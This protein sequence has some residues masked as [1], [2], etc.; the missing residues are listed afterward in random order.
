MNEAKLKRLLQQY[1]NNTISRADCVELLDYLKNTDPEEAARLIAEDM[2]NLEEGPEFTPQ[3]S[4]QIFNRIT[5]DPRFT[6]IHAESAK[7][8]KK[9]IKFYQRSWFRVAAAVLVFCTALGIMFSRKLSHT[10]DAG[11]YAVIRRSAVIVPGSEKATLTTSN[12]QVILLEDA[13]DGLLAKTA[14]YSVLKTGKGQIVYN[15]PNAAPATAAGMQYN[16]LTTPKGGEYQVVLPD[17]TKV[18]LNAASSL[19]YPTAFTGKER[20]V[21]LTGEAYFEVAKN[22][23]QPFYVSMNKVQVRVLG[24][25]FNISAYGDDDAVTTTLLEGAVQVKKNNTLSL[26]Q[27]GQQARVNNAANDIV[28]SKAKLDEVMAWK[29][30][31]FIFDD[32][33]ISGIMKKVSRWYDVD[34]QYQGSFDDQKFGG[35]F[36]RSKSITDLLH[37]LEKIGEIRFKISER[38]IIVMK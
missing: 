15:A 19:S 21:K 7:V 18:W 36:H 4:Q 6:G 31:Y 16:T 29:N 10:S 28:V 27:P 1:F 38:R 32:D 13:K 34:V 25:H 12:G 9:I 14:G 3:Q 20:R 24:T 37:Y 30:G 2:L 23:H 26:L 8:H 35:T 22:A 17:G 11:S 33:D 5:A